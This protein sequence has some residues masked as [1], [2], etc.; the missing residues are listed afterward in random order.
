M[1]FYLE[2]EYVINIFK[3]IWRMIDYIQTIY[4][5]QLQISFK[6]F[7][8]SILFFKQRILFA[9]FNKKKKKN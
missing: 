3:Y 1:L 7:H 4:L 8:N 6:I 5:A 9:V 2:N